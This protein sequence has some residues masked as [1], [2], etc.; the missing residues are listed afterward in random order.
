MRSREL[1]LVGVVA[2]L[3]ALPV[4]ARAESVRTT[5]SPAARDLAFQ[6]ELPYTDIAIN[7]T[8]GPNGENPSGQVRSV[9]STA[10]RAGR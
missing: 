10:C 4:T 7:A 2:V 1:A 3:L 5:G 9:P 6:I 8:S